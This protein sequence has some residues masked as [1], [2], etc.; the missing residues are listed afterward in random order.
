[1]AVHAKRVVKGVGRGD[2]AVCAA[3]VLKSDHPLNPA[4]VAWLAG[5]P[6]TKRKGREFL[7]LHPQYRQV[8]SV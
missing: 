2:N 3:D 4:F 6:A 5:K 8:Q 7:Q 1:M